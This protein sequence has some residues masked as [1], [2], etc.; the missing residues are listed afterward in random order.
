MSTDERRQPPGG[1]HADRIDDE[2]V[3]RIPSLSRLMRAVLP[4]EAVKHLQAAQREQLLALRAVLDGVISRMDAVE[5]E[6]RQAAR[7]TEIRID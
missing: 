4:T 1:I 6:D 2:V 5:P 7:R 3:L